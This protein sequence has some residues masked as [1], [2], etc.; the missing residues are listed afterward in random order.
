MADLDPQVIEAVRLQLERISAPVTSEGRFNF[1]PPPSPADTEALFDFH[2]LQIAYPYVWKSLNDKLL[3]D[4]TV[5][6]YTEWVKEQYG[7]ATG[8][9]ED[10][11]EE[12]IPQDID[13]LDSQLR[14]FLGRSSPY[15]EP[16]PP[17]VSV[18]FEI[19]PELWEWIGPENRQWI[20]GWVEE[21]GIRVPPATSSSTDRPTVEV[22][23]PW[24]DAR[25]RMQTIIDG[26]RSRMEEGLGSTRGW[27]RITAM[28]NELQSRL[29]EQYRFSVFAEST[30]NYGLLATYRQKWIPGNYQVGELVTTIPLAPGESRKFT[31]KKT[32]SKSRKRAEA[33]NALNHIK[34]EA[35]KT[36][37]AETDITQKTFLKTSFQN[38]STESIGIPGGE[39]GPSTGGSNTTV[40]SGDIS[41]ESNRVK[42][43]FREAILK[44]SAEYRNERKIEIETTSSEQIETTSSGEIR[45]PNDEI[46][47]TYLFYELQRRY[48]IEE[49]LHRVQPVVM[50][51]Q[52]VPPPH[53]ID[54]DWLITYE[55]ILRRVLLDDS[56][57]VALDYLTGG[58]SS[59]EL[60][61]VLKRQNLDVQRRV[62]AELQ[63]QFALNFK[64]RQRA[65]KQVER[66]L[67]GQAE[68]QGVIEDIVEGLF[69][70][71]VDDSEEARAKL[72]A[73]ERAV[74]FI[75]S[76]LAEAQI[77]YDVPQKR[78][79]KRLGNKWSIE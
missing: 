40:V 19:D 6:F 72:E 12:D 61:V 37:R 32:I 46:T 63:S 30:Y 22:R 23:A 1:R 5:D 41:R 11:P 60:N 55:W 24:Q 17:E 77:N 21:Q 42:K 69:G 71:G 70:T 50:V 67:A 8:E 31:A 56:F 38:T 66:G 39:D 59:D 73:A 13:E 26:W 74:E 52:H 28:I 44:T 3:Y 33:E 14:Q 34:T 9:I 7:P 62:V 10:L 25:D 75:E 51:A 18:A 48:M 76:D 16:V 58:L 15:G 65:R 2:T 27:R 20:I 47:V 78:C 4:N 29:K 49:N 64:A 53:E 79:P 54:E 57:N 43:N 68:S 36:R 35:S 45:N